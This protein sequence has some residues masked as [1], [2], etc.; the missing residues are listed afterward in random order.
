VGAAWYEY[1]GFD[2]D[3]VRRARAWYGQ[4]L[5]PDGA[6][7]D[8]GCGRGEFLDVAAA[9]GLCVEGVDADPAMLAGVRTHRVHQSDVLDFLQA[10]SARFDVITAF[11]VVEHWDVTATAAFVRH[12][13]AC[14]TPGGRLIVATPNPGSLPTSA[15]EFWRDPTHVRPY[16]VELLAFLAHQAGLRVLASGVNPAAERGLPVDLADMD[17]TPHD[18]PPAEEGER[19]DAPLRRWLG[20]QV[21]GGSYGRDLHAAIHRVAAELAHTRAE[22]ARISG[23]VRRALEVAY[24]PSEVYLVADKPGAPQPG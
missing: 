4:F 15:H 8:V 6:L 12:S 2:R 21:A 9:A 5:P 13:A 11:H 16:D 23:V 20:G 18:H 3:T 1:R 10:A 7:L 17:L 24:E 14:L 19:A 22:L